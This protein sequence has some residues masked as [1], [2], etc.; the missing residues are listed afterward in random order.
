MVRGIRI[1]S[2]DV[3]GATPP[4]LES[5]EAQ[6]AAARATGQA[7][8]GLGNQAIAISGQ[9]SQKKDSLSYVRETAESRARLA[10]RSQAVQQQ[11]N[12]YALSE[13]FDEEGYKQ[14]RSQLWTDAFEFAGENV[15][16][17]QV[18]ASLEG[19]RAGALNSDVTVELSEQKKRR[20]VQGI[21][22][23]GDM[24]LEFTEASPI[25]SFHEVASTLADAADRIVA[26]DPE[27]RE[28]ALRQKARV[29]EGMR[30]R[31]RVAGGRKGE[32]QFLAGVAHGDFDSLG[33]DVIGPEMTNLRPRIN[34]LIREELE[35]AVL[36]DSYG[37]Q[38]DKGGLFPGYQNDGESL[39][40]KALQ[41]DLEGLEGLEGARRDIGGV[42]AH[43]ERRAESMTRIEDHFE[44]GEAL[45]HMA[46]DTELRA[47]YNSFF[48]QNVAPWLE[49]DS[50]IEDKVK[51]LVRTS[52]GVG[53]WPESAQT[54]ITGQLRTT[55]PNPEVLAAIAASYAMLSPNPV[56]AASVTTSRPGLAAEMQGLKLPNISTD[57]LDDGDREL[58]ASMARNS[59]MDPALALQ[60]AQERQQLESQRGTRQAAAQGRA[61]VADALDEATVEKAQR[62]W[63]K[64]VDQ[65]KDRLSESFGVDVDEIGPQLNT[66]IREV[67]ESAL[68]RKLQTLPP[69]D[70]H[71]S[72]LDFALSEVMDSNPP[73]TLFGRTYL[74]GPLNDVLKNG[75]YPPEMIELEVS[76][77]LQSQGFDTSD[78]DFMKRVRIVRPPF[79][80]LN[81]GEFMVEILGTDGGF[82]SSAE[83]GGLL[84]RDEG[85]GPQILKI[86]GD[87]SLYERAQ[88][89]AQVLGIDEN[90][91]SK[92]AAIG[93][94]G[95]E[96]TRDDLL[97]SILLDSKGWQ[98][99]ASSFAPKRPVRPGFSVLRG[100]RRTAFA[101]EGEVQLLNTPEVRQLEAAGQ[102]GSF[103]Q[104]RFSESGNGP[105]LKS[106]P[107]L[108]RIWDANYQE[109]FDRIV[110]NQPGGRAAVRA[111]AQAWATAKAN[112]AA[113]EVA[114]RELET[115]DDVLNFIIV[116]SL[117]SER[118]LA[119]EQAE[120]EIPDNPLEFLRSLDRNE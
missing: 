117:P 38:V 96:E 61:S 97:Q 118:A 94:E 65:L 66:Q 20:N 90:S 46:R 26:E 1:Q 39:E 55:D 35:S 108:K 74:S 83:A 68:H 106:S 11:L 45:P 63:N 40:L 59:S 110:E 67:Y 7:A 2:R 98:R 57:W 70:A 10:T 93:L 51:T 103:M 41:A 21:T 82:F 109:E 80:S 9:L 75:D 111:Q 30:A 64:G 78:R 119:A 6:T 114:G 8:Q 12:E 89:A 88:S 14:L 49:G 76:E 15:S 91:Q 5:I 112:A 29:F 13:D 36:D 101:D 23:A 87:E 54:W 104:R 116:G 52:R 100:S 47:A 105:L 102:I 69:E 19:N 37:I 113:L 72:A 84:E 56:L 77:A 25:E 27:L 115:I 18:R 62:E 22:Q 4:V 50:P 3:A 17:P 31:S 92:L 43:R 24:A 79:A 34:N 81:E 16:H 73:V 95:A 28:Q 53:F 71:R 120:R 48:T 58:L 42:I 86:K 107:M 32:I 99:Y 44:T 60:V 33:L 85:E